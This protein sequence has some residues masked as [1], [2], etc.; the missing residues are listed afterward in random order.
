MRLAYGD[1]NVLKCNIQFLYDR[2]FTSFHKIENGV[3][4]TN[5]PYGIVNSNDVA[6]SLDLE[7]PK[8]S[9][10]GTSLNDRAS[11][12]RDQRNYEKNFGKDLSNFL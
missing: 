6:Q 9:D 3:A 7:P 5:T 2:F 4:P 1:S 12:L 10:Y 8:K 11:F